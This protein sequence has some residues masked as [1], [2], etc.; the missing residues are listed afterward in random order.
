MV[1]FLFSQ[2]SFASP[3]SI[4]CDSDEHTMELEDSEIHCVP[5]ESN[6]TCFKLTY[7]GANKCLIKEEPVP[8]NLIGITIKYTNTEEEEEEIVVV[9]ETTEETE[10]KTT[11]ISG[12][13]EFLRTYE[14]DYEKS[15]MK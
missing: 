15:N 2:F 8:E 13:I 4:F 10:G 14:P 7:Q 5:D 11:F 9:N 12:F 6:L 1:F 3:S